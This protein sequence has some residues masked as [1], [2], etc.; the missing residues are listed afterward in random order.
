MQTTRTLVTWLASQAVHE[1]EAVRDVA[2]QLAGLLAAAH[3]AFRFH[4]GLSADHVWVGGDLEVTLHGWPHEPA[5]PAARMTDLAAAGHLLQRLSDQTTGRTAEALA[6]ASERLIGRRGPPID[7]AQALVDTVRKVPADPSRNVALGGLVS[8]EDADRVDA[9][10]DD[11]H[12]Y[13]ISAPVLASVPTADGSGVGRLDLRL[14]VVA[15]VVVLLLGGA[16][17]VGG[18]M[19]RQQHLN[20]RVDVVHWAELAL[21][22]SLDATAGWVGALAPRGDA[23]MVVAAWSAYSGASERERFHRALELADALREHGDERGMAAAGLAESAQTARS[24]LERAEQGG[25]V[26]AVE[27]LLRRE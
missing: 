14:L 19:V 16:L 20:Q 22:Q 25:V 17:T 23:A 26:D 7:T 13:E 1:P 21:F 9:L 5:L 18:Q 12:L 8:F 11:E 27:A 4:G 3:V 24:R 15:G 10:R 6:D 2:L